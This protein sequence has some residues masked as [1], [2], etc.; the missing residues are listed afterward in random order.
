M[1][2]FKP[3]GFMVIRDARRS[4]NSSRGELALASSLKSSED[5]VRFDDL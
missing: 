4:A 2:T 3:Q 5:S 1:T